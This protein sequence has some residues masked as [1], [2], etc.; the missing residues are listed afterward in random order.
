M[1]SSVA[2]EDII[3]R[4]GDIIR[5]DIGDEIFMNNEASSAPFDRI[6]SVIQCDAWSIY[7]RSTHA[8][9]RVANNYTLYMY[10][11]PGIQ[12]LQ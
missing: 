7:L 8:Q 3:Y 1:I 11:T 5:C 9:Y 4:H 6:Q 12:M 2:N 10:V